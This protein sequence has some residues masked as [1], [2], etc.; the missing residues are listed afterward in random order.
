MFSYYNFKY[1]LLL[2]LCISLLYLRKDTQK[3][4][5]CVIFVSCIDILTSMIF[6]EYVIQK[7]VA[8]IFLHI[9]THEPSKSVKISQMKVN[10]Y[11]YKIRWKFGWGIL[12][13]LHRL[14]C[15]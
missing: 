12:T 1:K 11:L 10:F 2:K 14:V 3:K 15:T 7:T 6:N 4:W 13:V 8:L 5:R 9:A